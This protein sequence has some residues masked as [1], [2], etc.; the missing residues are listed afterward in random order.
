MPA[1]VFVLAFALFLPSFDAYFAVLDF[2]HL[3]AIRRTDAATFFLRIFDPSDGGRTVIGTGDLYRPIYYSVFWLEYQLFGADPTPYYVFNAALHATNAVLVWSLAWRLTRSRLAAG[4]GALVWAFHPQYADAVAWVSSTTDLLLVFFALS[5]V[6]LYARAL[7]ASGHGRW[8]AYGGSFAATLLAIG[9]KETGVVTVPLIIAYHVL[10]AQPDMLRRHR[11]PWTLLPF[12]LV[13]LVYFPMR[14]LLVGNLATEGE[15]TFLTWDMARNVHRLSG[16]AGGP[17]VGQTISNS[18]YGVGQ[19]VAGLGIVAFTLVMALVGSRRDWFAV[20][21]YYVALVPVLLFPQAW[22][23]GRY[24]YLPMVG[25]A[26]VTGMAVA[27]VADLLPAWRLASLRRGAVVALAGGLVVWLGVLNLGYQ[28]WLNEKGEDAERFI[29]ALKST[30][31]S[32]PDGGRLIV[33]EHPRSLSLTPDDGMMLVPAVHIAYG[34]DIE[35]VTLQQLERQ[36]V[37]VAGARDVWYP[38]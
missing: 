29:A 15:S 32:L 9:A 10:I 26:L 6:L 20:S 27:R 38:P 5:A 33:T 3:D 2:N 22:L 18:D 23:V 28:S 36:G 12:V 16:L 34:R 13:P 19:G 14:A 4:V 31:P 30:Y 7:D 35:V 8:L 25:L 37:T 24:L 1:V 11:V 21:W 17:F